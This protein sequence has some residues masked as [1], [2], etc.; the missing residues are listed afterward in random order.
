M[1]DQNSRSTSHGRGSGNRRRGGASTH[2]AN[3]QTHDLA[4]TGT[5]Q[6][7]T[8]TPRRSARVVHQPV[9]TYAEP[10]V[11]PDFEDDQ[12]FM[13]P[14]EED[15]RHD[16]LEEIVREAED[17]PA[18]RDQRPIDQI[19]AELANIRQLLLDIANR[20]HIPPDVSM[21]PA[22]QAVID[23]LHWETIADGES[24]GECPIC[25]CDLVGQ[26]VTLDCEHR[27]CRQCIINWLRQSGTCPNCRRRPGG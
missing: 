1:D 12:S 17:H 5:S 27:F 15:P 26:V 16:M 2:H 13:N 11:D 3:E 21:Q 23:A 7:A 18:P 22:S 14:E 10:D 9:V 8:E 6:Q 19:D 4:E 25:K 20:P 24:V